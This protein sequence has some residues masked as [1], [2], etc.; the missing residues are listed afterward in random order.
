V[1]AP[2]DGVELAVVR[3]GYGVQRMALV[4]WLRTALFA[5]PCAQTARAGLLQSVTA[6]GLAAVA[7]VFAQLVLKSLNP[8]LEVEDEGS[9]LP[10]EGQHGFFALHV[11]GMDIVSGRQVSGY[12]V[13]YC[14]L[15][16]AV[17]HEEMLSSW[18]A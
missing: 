11:G 12:H 2:L 18:Y 1:P 13:I 8:C 17:L 15:L 10:H 3:L 4:A 16:L 5:A 14:A 9:Q 7:T 6:R